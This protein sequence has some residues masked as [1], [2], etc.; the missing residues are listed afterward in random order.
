MTTAATTELQLPLPQW[1]EQ[2]LSRL[3]SGARFAGVYTTHNGGGAHLRALLVLRDDVESLV[4]QLSPEPDGRLTYPALSPDVPAAFWYERALHDL[5]GVTPL[6]HPRLDPLLLPLEPGQLSPRPGHPE[7]AEEDRSTHARASDLLGPV[8]VS[9]HGVFTLPLGPVRS[10]V[11]ESIE[12]LIETPGEDIPHFNIRPHY[13]HRGIAKRFEGLSIHDATLVAERVEGIASVAHALAFAHA[14]ETLADTDVPPKAELIRVI[15]AELERIVNHLDVAVRLCD[16]AGL[17]IGT[18]RFGW[19]KEQAMRLVSALCGNRFGRSVVCVG[20]VT[21]LP[22]LDPA[23]ISRAV[24]ELAGRIRADR[25]AVMESPSFL[26]RIRSTGRLDA[27][28]ARSHGAL[29]PVGRG[30]GFDDDARLYRSYDGYPD[31][32]PAAPAISDGCD[33]MARLRVRW[34]EI[35][36][37]VELIEA[38][39]HRLTG[40][41]HCDLAVDVDIIDGFATGWAESPQ[42]EVLYGVELRDGRVGRCFARTA[43]LHNMVLFHD[44]FHGDVFT[45]FPFIE[46]SFG[47]CYA[48]VA[49]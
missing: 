1:R 30:S 23:E 9:G 39:S 18:S 17:A 19:H 36:T 37:A 5:S 33:A 44:V 40:V 14:V 28:L 24:S 48:G 34:A 8:D 2:V 26:D 22:R 38:A 32:P 16:A 42:G 41:V 4:T 6:G 20:G 7:P 43:S 45:D 11:Y 13:K 46:A 21:G 3:A 35:D 31:L 12:F 29:G 49:M 47:L 15:H 25:R 27:Q 10:G